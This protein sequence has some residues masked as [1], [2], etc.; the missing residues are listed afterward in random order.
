MN[1]VAE[2][3]SLEPKKGTMKRKFIFIAVIA[4]VVLAGAFL[5]YF[6]YLENPNRQVLARVNDEKV[7]VEQFNKE[8]AKMET[9]LMR[10]MLREEPDKFLEGMI[11]NTL[12]LQEAK[13]RGG[14]APVK[15]YKDAEKGARSSEESIITE[16]M[17]K[18]FSSPPEV[19]H[20]EI[21]AFYKIY[22]ER[23]E[24]KP[25][26]E[27]TPAI[28]QIIR[29]MK[30]REAL[31]Q[32]LGE[33]RKNA[34]VEI[35]Q[36]RLQKIAVKPPESNTEEELKQAL[37]S[38]KPILADFGANSCV[39]CR[40]MR[41]ILKEIGAEYSQKARVLVIDVYKYQNL[42]R[43][44]KVMLIPT[45]IFFDSKGKEVFRHVGAWGKEEIVAK[46]KEIGMAS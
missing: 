35:N 1:D 38:G 15:T 23:M 19:T 11:V 25:L 6:F 43:D 32:F 45:L 26:K 9:P 36:E 40:Q 31:G 14:S 16:F 24:G 18:K 17:E 27:V 21:E 13:K 12:L 34:K 44:Y 3:Q 5:F 7:T 41:P 10:D 46:L 33:L 22:K 37:T 29:E 20:E 42:A 4:I 8:L 2:E 39:P 28:E 30:Q